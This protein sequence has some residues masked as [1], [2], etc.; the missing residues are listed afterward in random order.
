[1]ADRAGELR[2]I[3]GSVGVD[4]LQAYKGRVPHP[5]RV[6]APSPTESEV[7]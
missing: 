4:T 5:V 7:G 1:V 3:L 6:G 2:D